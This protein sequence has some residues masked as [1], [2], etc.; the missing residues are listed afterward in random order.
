[1][2]IGA[3]AALASAAHD[4]LRGFTATQHDPAEAT[5]QL[6]TTAQAI[7]EV[8]IFEQLTGVIVTEVLMLVVKAFF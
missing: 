3:P 7:A 6:Q 4:T 1:M 5:H 2:R 8:L